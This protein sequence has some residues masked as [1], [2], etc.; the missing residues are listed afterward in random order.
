[1]NSPE[2]KV[3][4]EKVDRLEHHF[5]VYKSDLSD[6]KDLSKE[7]K[8]ILIG[9]QM[10]GNAGVIQLLK[11]IENRVDDLSNKNI[12]LEE[13]MRNVK[14]ISRGLITAIIGFIFWLFT[15]KQ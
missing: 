10:N 9:S 3:I 14:Y 2:I 13:N 6:M 8:G 12:L 11:E 15:N 5:K 1:M 4:G 7:I